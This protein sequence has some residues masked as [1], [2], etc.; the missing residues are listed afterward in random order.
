MLCCPDFS[1]KG[2]C[3]CRDSHS[4]GFFLNEW[5]K[6]SDILLDVGQFGE[7]NI[8]VIKIN[9][10]QSSK[11]VYCSNMAAI[12]LFQTIRKQNAFIYHK[13]EVFCM[14]CRLRKQKKIKENIQFT[15]KIFPTKNV[16]LSVFICSIA[17]KVKLL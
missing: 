12:M 3:V 4:L 7:D 14:R 2:V 5:E 13:E 10:V 11:Q 1:F 9:I 8:E 6:N 16:L 15:L 17:L